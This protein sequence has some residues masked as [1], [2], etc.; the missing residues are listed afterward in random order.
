[1]LLDFRFRRLPNTGINESSFSHLQSG[2]RLAGVLDPRHLVNRRNIGI[3]FNL[4][5]T[6]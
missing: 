6:E 4:G 1:M 3:L 5:A 2:D